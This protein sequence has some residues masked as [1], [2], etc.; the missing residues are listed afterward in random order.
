MTELIVG[1][2]GS[3][4]TAELIKRSAKDGIYIMTGTR[5]QAQC[6]F[7]QAR[8][9]GYNIPFPVTLEDYHRTHF[10]GSCLERDG[11]L[12]DELGPML[13]YMFKGVPINGVTWTKDEFTD[14]D[15][16]NPNNPWIGK[17]PYIWENENEQN[18]RK[19][20]F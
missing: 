2:R 1:S 13:S 7:Q 9:M 16:E 5:R 20:I 3:G 11:I 18:H 8:D 14:L 10:R 6:I 4:K 15:L 19:P 12:I 17:N